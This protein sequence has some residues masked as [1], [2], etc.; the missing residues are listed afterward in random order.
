MGITQHSDFLLTP[1]FLLI[2]QGLLVWELNLYFISKCVFILS[3]AGIH[4]FAFLHEPHVKACPVQMKESNSGKD[5]VGR[6]TLLAISLT[7]LNLS[8]IW[9][10]EGTGKPWHSKCPGYMSKWKHKIREHCAHPPL[11]R[12]QKC[13]VQ[14]TPL[15][16]PCLISSQACWAFLLSVEPHSSFMRLQDFGGI[17][18]GASSIQ[19]SSISLLCLPFA[20]CMWFMLPD[21]S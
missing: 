16:S 15:P 2:K 5:M 14:S 20:H 18:Q 6:Q 9:L 11:V 21:G 4:D 3:S 12:K 8:V 19:P 13:L 10:I 1:T 17:R 7:P